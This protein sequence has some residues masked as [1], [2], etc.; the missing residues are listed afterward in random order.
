MLYFA[1]IDNG[2]VVNTI[3]CESKDIAEELSGKICVEYTE[4]DFVC[5]GGTYEDGKFWQPQPFL[6]WVKNQET[7][8]W[9]PPVERPIFNPENP[10]NYV[11]D[12]NTTS[13]LQIEE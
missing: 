6:S 3:V 8:A 1:V 11:W 9:D 13:W 7:G 12:E 5:I 4:N 2:F 10:K